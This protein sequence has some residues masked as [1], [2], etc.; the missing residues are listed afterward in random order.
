MPVIVGARPEL[1]YKF[2]YVNICVHNDMCEA[3][4]STGRFQS[5]FNQA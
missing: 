3:R 1:Q 2:D 5:A 4:G